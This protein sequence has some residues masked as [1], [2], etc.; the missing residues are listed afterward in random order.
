MKNNDWKDR[1]GILYSTNPNFQYDTG[2]E[3]YHWISETG[4]ERL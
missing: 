3:E 4:E 1:L 2:E